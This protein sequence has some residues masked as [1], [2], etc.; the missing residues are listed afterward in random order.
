MPSTLI[1]RPARGTAGPRTRFVLRPHPAPPVGLFLSVS[2]LQFLLHPICAQ[3]VSTRLFLLSYSSLLG[4][5]SHPGQWPTA[6]FSGKSDD[7]FGV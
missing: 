3:L 5:L 1:T 6:R 4:F 2:A 7:L